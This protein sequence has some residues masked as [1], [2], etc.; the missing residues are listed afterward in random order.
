VVAVGTDDANA[1]RRYTALAHYCG[2]EIL[3]SDGRFVCRSG[4]TC[5]TSALR[6]PGRA[7]FEGQLSYLGRHYD[8]CTDEGVPLRVLVVPMETGREREHVD[9]ETRRDEVLASAALPFRKRN[10]HMRGV[11]LALRLA[12]GC[13][14]DEEPE[15]EYLLAPGGG[16]HLFEAFAM[17]NL[18][19]CSAVK[20]ETTKSAQT[21][22]MRSQCSRHL[23]ATVNVLAPTLVISQGKRLSPALNDLFALETRHSAQVSTRTVGGTRFVWVDLFHPTFTW[24]WLA[25]PYLWQVAVPAIRLARTM[26]L[27]ESD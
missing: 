24:D 4:S 13:D 25:R 15:G 12:F 11:T 9:L 1:H 19:L 20:T 16:I 18:L 3:T 27:T 10:P 6:R 17:A 21:A 26:A 5:A 7:F 22:V 23:A 14:L 8:T 2:S